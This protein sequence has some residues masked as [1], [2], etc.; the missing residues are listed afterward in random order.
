MAKFMEFYKKAVGEPE[1]RAKLEA[2]LSGK[3]MD[4]ANDQQ[5]EQ[6]GE[7]A[8]SLGYT[9]TMDEVKAFLHPKE[10]SE[11]SDDQ[12]DA[13]AGGFLAQGKEDKMITCTGAGAQVSIVKDDP[14]HC[15]MAA[16]QVEVTVDGK[17]E[18]Q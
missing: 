9:F 4:Q 14:V 10:E 7:V 15:T 12:L 3:E 5:L 8:K 1:I 2:I 13:V 11:L 18:I 17:I 6:I 16:G